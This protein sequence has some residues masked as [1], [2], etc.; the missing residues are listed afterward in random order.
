MTRRLILF[1][2]F[3]TTTALPATEGRAG[4]LLL[5]YNDYG[6]GL[7]NVERV[8][9]LRV[10]FRDAGL[11][12]VNGINLTLWTPGDNPRAVVNGA[13]LNLLWAGGRDLNGL[14]VALVG[15][16][17]EN[18][19]GISFGLL[20]STLGALLGSAFHEWSVSYP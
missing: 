7:G 20:G 9:G 4:G 15:L 11:E 16:G 2:L 10:N 18:I 6:I 3:V 19:R 1:I 8:N 17:A 13:S 5:G 14:S 12:R